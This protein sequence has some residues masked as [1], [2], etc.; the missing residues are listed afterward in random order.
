MHPSSR[1]AQGSLEYLLLIGGGI[2]VVVVV[3]SILATGILPQGNLQVQND[4]QNYNEQLC[5]QSGLFT[6][7]QCANIDAGPPGE[8][9][10]FNI[11]F[12]AANPSTITFSWL[13]PGDD[14]VLQGGLI[15]GY[16]FK[17]SPTIIDP[18]GSNFSSATDITTLL[19]PGAPALPQPGPPGSAGSYTITNLPAGS[20]YF[21]IRAIDNAQPPQYSPTIAVNH[22]LISAS[23]AVRGWK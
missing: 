9:R 5:N 6:P 13:W 19:G 4:V 10:N 1:K 16:E 8:F 12:A 7:A 14:G 11:S 3:V 17:Y 22:S 2:L 15:S 23:V 21:G 18:A 20:Y